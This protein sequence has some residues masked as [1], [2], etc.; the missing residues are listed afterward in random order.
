M[1]K[2]GIASLE[3]V[4]IINELQFLVKG[5]ISQVYHQEKM[6]LLFQLHAM[7]E[8]KKLLKI[9]PGKFLCLTS[10]KET[11]LKPSSFCM[12]LRK[13]LNNAF[14]KKIEQKGSERI[15]VFEIEKADKYYLII[16]LFSRGNLILTDS[17]DMIIA[18]LEQKKWKDRNI[19]VKE[20]Y[21]F[22]APGIDWKKMNEK[23]LSSVLK[24]SEKKNLATSM[25]TEM[26]FGGL[27][28]EEI[29]T[30][31]GV[32]KDKLQKDVTEK[33]VK[34]L[35]KGIKALLKLIEKPAGFIYEKEITPFELKNE[36][37]VL[38]KKTKTYNEAI[39]TLNPFEIISPYEQKI[40][41]AKR[42]I[43]GQTKSIKKQEVKIESNTKK[44]ETIY[45]NY[46][47]LQKIIDFVNSAR[48]EGKDWKEIEK[49][50]KNIKKIKGIDL[51][52]KKILLEF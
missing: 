41:S 45:D 1:T 30:L 49:E 3:L 7:G 40:L 9:V 52:N 19:R 27:Y 21:T 11:P 46:Q 24:K 29:C 31:A 6:E 16:E 2:K 26:G 38:D 17:K 44:G 50:L 32:D 39:D 43:S 33:E 12:Q 14:I 22:P 47:P 15:I 36:A 5:R 25:A 18:A 28:A 13:Y 48:K 51:K 35:V 4:A 8:G 42:I 34:S 10:R 23:E 37:V 20:K